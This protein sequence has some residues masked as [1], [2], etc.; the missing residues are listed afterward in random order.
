MRSRIARPRR[1]ML[2]SAWCG[3]RRSQPRNRNRGLRRKFVECGS[4][5]AAVPVDGMRDSQ[6][7][8]QGSRTPHNFA[9][10]GQIACPECCFLRIAGCRAGR[11]DWLLWLGGGTHSIIKRWKPESRQAVADFG[12]PEKER[13]VTQCGLQVEP[14][15]ETGHYQNQEPTGC[16]RYDRQKRQFRGK[17]F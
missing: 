1:S 15:P 2:D 4:R 5:A 9:L 8:E 16:R 14:A 3:E 10:C 11:P 13:G 7:R 6:K 17:Q 12:L